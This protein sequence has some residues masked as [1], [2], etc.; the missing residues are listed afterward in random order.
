MSDD[1]VI[2]IDVPIDIPRFTNVQRAEFKRYYQAKNPLP[3]E[4]ASWDEFWNNVCILQ[5]HPRTMGHAYDPE[6]TFPVEK[7]GH[8]KFVRWWMGCFIGL[9][10]DRK[11]KWW[12]IF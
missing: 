3:S 4:Y 1:D 12:Q 10:R 6:E 9:Q 8:H 11:K 5:Q 7:D 2:A